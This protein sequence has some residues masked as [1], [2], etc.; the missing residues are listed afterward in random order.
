MN[1]ITKEQLEHPKANI[2]VLGAAGGNGFEHLDTSYVKNIYAVDINNQYLDELRKKY[3]FLG[4]ALK[5]IQ[6]DLSDE[7]AVIPKSNLLICNL[8]IEYLG[9]ER[10]ENLLNK[11]KSNIEI[12]SCVIQKNNGNIF[13][14]SSESA[15]QLAALT[16]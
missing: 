15:R 5:T 16:V 7:T 13:V 2:T 4:P 8:I 11:N 1:F 12:I 14:S 3:A 6:C 10:F 9:L